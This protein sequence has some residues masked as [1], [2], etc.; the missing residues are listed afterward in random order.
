MRSQHSI[1]NGKT[2][3]IDNE[4]PEVLA[5]L[6]VQRMDSEADA[7]I[8]KLRHK[9]FEK[10]ATYVDRKIAEHL[11]ENAAI[12]LMRVKREIDE[13]ITY[14]QATNGNFTF[15]LSCDG[16]EFKIDKRSFA[17]FGFVGTPFD[18]FLVEDHT[19]YETN[20]ELYAAY[21]NDCNLKGCMP[22]SQIWLGR[23]IRAFFPNVTDYRTNDT[24]RLRGIHGV[25]IKK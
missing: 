11:N 4:F 21:V 7:Q 3:N 15:V 12:S 1:K 17:P 22:K 20:A 25:R 14:S 13:H 5:R 6:V 8:A 24:L 18:D 19:T 16:N 23:N 2:F 9:P 10:V